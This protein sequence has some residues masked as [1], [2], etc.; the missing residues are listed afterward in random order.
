MIKSKRF[1]EDLFFRIAI[2][3]F[4]TKPLRERTCDVRAICDSFIAKHN[5][6]PLTDE[7]L[8]APNVYESGNVRAL[9]N[10]LHRKEIG[11]KDYSTYV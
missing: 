1:R 2:L 3:E 6:T 7:E 9:L 4:R 11:I 5:L 8:P 10:W